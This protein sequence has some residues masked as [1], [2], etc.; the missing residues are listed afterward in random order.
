MVILLVLAT[1]VLFL[2]LEAF[3]FYRQRAHVKALAVGGGVYFHPGHTWASFQPTGLVKVGLDKFIRNVVGKFDSMTV[4]SSGRIVKQGQLLMTL[5]R[6][7]KDI[8]IM[9]PLDGV[10]IDANYQ[11]SDEKAFK[12]DHLLVIRP[13]HVTSN[14]PKMKNRKEAE[15]WI[16][17]E[18]A[19]FREFIGN[20]MGSGELGL[21]MADG[22]SHI[23]EVIE[24]MD[25]ATLKE[26]NREFLLN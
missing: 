25:E 17:S 8:F 16:T 23:D 15:T 26:F 20:R 10:V 6:K 3:K 19:R 18:L 24:H 12:S 4:P 9:S 5:N 14:M 21:T 2:S 13:T 11:I 1:L 7:G 22:G